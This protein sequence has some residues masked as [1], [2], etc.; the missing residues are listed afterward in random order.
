MHV[1]ANW[2][3]PFTH[4]CFLYNQSFK[5]RA[6]T[7]QKR[8]C[9]KEIWQAHGKRAGSRANAERARVQVPKTTILLFISALW[10]IFPN[11]RTLGHYAKRRP[12]FFNCSY[13]PIRRQSVTC[14]KVLVFK[15]SPE[16][17]ENPWALSRKSLSRTLL[18][19]NLPYIVTTSKRTLSVFIGQ[20]TFRNQAY[21]TTLWRRVWDCKISRAQ[22]VSQWNLWTGN[23]FKKTVDYL[24]CYTG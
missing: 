23:I 17:Q 15:G 6:S 20:I 24:G 11:R 8:K 5:K 13:V 1:F 18:Y 21:K 2:F 14:L 22:D 4:Y 10:K 9:E 3:F 16:L 7:N 19:M 12:P